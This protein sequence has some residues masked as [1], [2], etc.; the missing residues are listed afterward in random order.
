MTCQC[1]PLREGQSRQDLRRLLAGRSSLSQHHILLSTAGLLLTPGLDG[2]D[3]QFS[4]LQF[5]SVLK[6]R[7][8]PQVLSLFILYQ[9]T[10]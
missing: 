5:E 1:D 8:S 10:Q 2:V 9:Y 3:H 4:K 7:A 6:D